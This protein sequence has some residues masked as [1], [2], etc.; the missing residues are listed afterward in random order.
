[1]RASTQPPLLPMHCRV[2][3]S[4]QYFRDMLTALIRPMVAGGSKAPLSIADAISAAQHQSGRAV[5][6]GRSSAA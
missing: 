6:V 4:V 3:Y 5:K 2:S 1:M